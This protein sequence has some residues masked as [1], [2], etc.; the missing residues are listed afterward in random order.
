MWNASSLPLQPLLVAEIGNDL[1]LLQKW[2]DN[3]DLA[4]S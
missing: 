3:S 4:I 1:G 2:G